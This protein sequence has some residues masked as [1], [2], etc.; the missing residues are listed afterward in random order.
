MNKRRKSFFFP[1]SSENLPFLIFYSYVILCT[2]SS[3]WRAMWFV[4][5]QFFHVYF[6][7]SIFYGDFLT[8]LIAKWSKQRKQSWHPIG[9]CYDISVWLSASWLTSRCLSEGASSMKWRQS[10]TRSS[11]IFNL[12]IHLFAASFRVS[13]ISKWTKCPQDVEPFQ[14]HHK[15]I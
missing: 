2:F 3:F 12:V 11:L 13:V 9:H 1:P 15:G 8:K 7:L 5:S 6:F 14:C 10:L 4:C